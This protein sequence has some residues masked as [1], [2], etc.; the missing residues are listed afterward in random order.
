MNDS[1]RRLVVA[2]EATSRP[3]SGVDNWAP[4]GPFQQRD[5]T[6]VSIGMTFSP[7][8]V[9]AALPPNLK[10]IEGFR[11]GMMMTLARQGFMLAPF[12]SSYIWFDIQDHEGSSGP[13]RFIC[14]S[15]GSHS[16][17]HGQLG[18]LACS[19]PLAI[20]ESAHQVIVT[21]GNPQA[22]KLRA[23]LRP[24][25]NWTPCAG[26]ENC[27]FDGSPIHPALSIS[28]V[29]WAAEWSDAAPERVEF[30]APELADLTPLSL[31]WASIG[32]NAAM[33]LGLTRA[34]WG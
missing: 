17:D 12:S 28:V 1:P 4:R 5:A 32:K 3:S 24:A 14:R 20:A 19:L 23:L 29:P 26:V 6:L 30:L 34:I 16:A 10:P 21:L 9:K 25:N 15:F 8:V 13:G 22:P 7:D 2:A 18:L 33:T 27:I 31:D 11:G